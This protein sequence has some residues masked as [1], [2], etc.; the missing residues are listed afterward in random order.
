MVYGVSRC[1]LGTLRR[2]DI[3][4][5]RRDIG[6]CIPGNPK[7]YHNRCSSLEL[8]RHNLLFCRVC[9]HR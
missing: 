3:R 4:L 8:R 9:G 6:E 5:L 7:T 1:V 2:V